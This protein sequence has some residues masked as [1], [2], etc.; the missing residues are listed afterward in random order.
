MLD[1]LAAGVAQQGDLDRAIEHARRRL[2]LDP[3]HEPAHQQLMELYS[4]SGERGAALS[5]YR[6]CVRV[7]HRELG[8]S[9]LD[10]T[11]ELYRAIREG[12]AVP[13]HGDGPA[14]A[15]AAPQ[16]A[17]V[18]R[19]AE[20][21]DAQ[22]IVDSVGPDGRLLVVEGEAGIGKTRFVAEL[23]A[24][25][26]ARGIPTAVARA[27][28]GEGALAYGTV[29]ELVRAALRS[30]SADRVA[31]GAR[32]EAARLMPELGT[33]A[34]GSLDDPG[35]RARFFDGIVSTLVD[36]LAHGPRA[37]L[38][39]DDVHWADASSLELISYLARR[40]AERPTLLVLTWRPEETSSRHPAREALRQAQN[41][42]RA[43]VIRLGRLSRADVGVLA[44]R[45]ALSGEQVDR[46]Y[47][48]T[49]GVPFFVCEYL[50]AGVDD[51]AA[52]PA[53]VRELVEA[54]L[55]ATSDVAGQVLA[56]GSVL[57]RSF[58]TDTVRMVS[59]RS[60]EEVVAALE[61]L[62]TRGV[63]VERDD[64]SY[65]FRHD[66][67][68]NVAYER[69]SSGRRRLLH[70]RAADALAAGARG[71]TAASI[72]GQHLRLAGRE[73]EAAEWYV[74]AGTRAHELHANEEA[75]AH[76]EEALALG[77]A[78]GAMLNRAIGDLL[79]LD[80]RY[81]DALRSFEAAAALAG[82]DDRATIEH[83]IGLVHHRRGEWELADDAFGAALALTPD[84]NAT[85]R[86]RILA[87][88]SL[89]AHRVGRDGEANDLASQ[90]LE[91]GTRAVDDR[92][93]AQA[94]NILGILAGGRGDH[95][96]AR[97]HAERSLALAEAHADDV[98]RIAA[99]NNLALV[100]RSEG[101]LDRA[102]ERTQEARRLCAIVGD[103]HR[104]A[105]LANNTADLLHAVGRADE[106]MATLK[107]AVSI[108]A[109]I[110]DTGDLEPEIWKLREW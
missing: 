70:G 89:T 68:R 38:V 60:D 9:P 78:D 33:P 20:L 39:V 72:V 77:H 57:G 71:G 23:A 31:A 40:L 64:T 43:S 62:V 41:D 34:V 80:G 106:A 92:A 93:A 94:H 44:Q 102:L 96:A 48:E 90:A 17:F 58:D 35:A 21:I 12:V 42:G 104:E 3:L 74:A 24:S 97:A 73:P 22:R 79:T 99:L 50:D 76:F 55:A 101:E 54:R 5:Q 85:E 66:Q 107:E 100:D 28:E 11:T 14:P 51:W 84:E 19:A 25:S 108:F 82:E 87:D 10:S 75:R 36:S 109:E 81:N 27:F 61:E 46:L 6:D 37:L 105:A 49:D 18:G 95:A 2:A 110:G 1:L 67:T 13:V 86:A 65:D 30:G 52:V 45:D 69:T 15:V 91:L 8:V 56:G 103:R 7:L 4:R 16:R 47:S 29:V 53:G 98:A 88:R 26:A 32:E 63:L 83:R 59:G